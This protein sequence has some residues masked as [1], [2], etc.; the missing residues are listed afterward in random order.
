M[1][2]SEIYIAQSNYGIFFLYPGQCTKTFP[3]LMSLLEIRLSG[4]LFAAGLGK[5]LAHKGWELQLLN[6]MNQRFLA[7]EVSRN[8]LCFCFKKRFYKL[9]QDLKQL[10]ARASASEVFLFPLIVHK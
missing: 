2:K 4:L 3:S 6:S 7:R 10:I 1:L 5:E 9:L 8:Q